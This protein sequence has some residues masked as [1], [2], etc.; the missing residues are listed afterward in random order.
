MSVKDLK[1][2]NQRRSHSTSGLDRKGRWHTT[3]KDGRKLGLKSV[4]NIKI[5]R[6]S[7]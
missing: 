7:R 1:G 6:I 4:G 2:L 5:T 3:G